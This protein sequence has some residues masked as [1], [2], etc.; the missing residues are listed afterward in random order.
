MN[1]KEV[2]TIVQEAQRFMKDVSVSPTEEDDCMKVELTFSD[3]K[4]H[5]LYL[6]VAKRKKDKRFTV[7]MPVGSTGL[8]ATN[9]TLSL[10]QPLLKSYGLIL[11]Q[12]A[13]IVEE[14]INLALHKRIR[15]M[16]QALVAVD[17]IC[18]LWNVTKELSEEEKVATKS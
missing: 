6:F 18:R 1:K 9:Q 11:T 2:H 10:L 13:V 14:N 5:L 8:L 17:G 3:P 7:M 4:S 12:D 16:S 15:N